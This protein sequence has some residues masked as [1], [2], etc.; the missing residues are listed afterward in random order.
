MIYLS[1]KNLTNSSFSSGDN[2]ATKCITLGLLGVPKLVS[3]IISTSNV[4][5]SFNGGM[6]NIPSSS[7]LEDFSPLDT[8]P[9]FLTFSQSNGAFQFSLRDLFLL[10]FISS[11]VFNSATRR[12]S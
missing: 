7:A 8:S 6:S 3:S 10:F 12:W 5:I 11:H 4:D 1:R 2:E 9:F